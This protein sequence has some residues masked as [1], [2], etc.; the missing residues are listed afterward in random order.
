[1]KIGISSFVWVSPF[2]SK[3]I[4]ILYKAK[5]FGYDIVEVAVE[6]EELIDLKLLK[7]TAKQVGLELSVSGAFG[8]ER[9]ISSLDKEVRDNGL[10]YIKTCVEI[11]NYLESPIFGGPMYSAVGKTRLVSEQQKAIER[12]YCLENLFEATNYASEMGI[13]L[14]LEPLNRFETDMINT[15]EQAISLIDEINHPSLRVLLDT[16]HTNIEEK[17]V[18][19]A[20]H[21]LGDKLVHVQG[22]ENDRGIP[23]T[24]QVPWLEIRD[25]LRSIN[26][27]GSIVLETF[28]SPS[29]E[30]ARAASIWRPLAKSADILAK[31]GAQFFTEIFK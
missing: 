30:L 14:A 8:L 25:A 9:D 22:N 17:D 15:V 7:T 10:A 11:A 29:K 26:Y 2:S 5:D 16:F 28:G 21:L 12:G 18:A 3:D 19:K 31:E 6:N 27:Q 20:I 24:G 4:D 1:M 13:T 23:G